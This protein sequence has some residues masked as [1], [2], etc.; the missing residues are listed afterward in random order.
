MSY[1]FK[2]TKELGAEDKRMHHK[3]VQPQVRSGWSWDWWGWQSWSDRWSGPVLGSLCGESNLAPV[4][5]DYSGMGCELSSLGWWQFHVALV[6][7]HKD[8]INSVPSRIQGDC[9]VTLSRM[10]YNKNR[11]KMEA[12]MP[13]FSCLVNSVPRK[14]SLLFI[15][16]NFNEATLHNTLT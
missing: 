7:C 9:K 1:R 2:Y 3:T 4:W 14:D 13:S 6:P 8:V 16:S 15:E 10:A 5:E 12:G 11:Y